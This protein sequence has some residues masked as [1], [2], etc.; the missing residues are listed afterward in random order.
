M[1]LYCIREMPLKVRRLKALEQ[2]VL[3]DPNAIPQN[4]VLLNPSVADHIVYMRDI[5]VNPKPP[6]DHPL[7]LAHVNSIVL[8]DTNT[9]TTIPV[10]SPWQLLPPSLGYYVGLEDLRIIWFRSRLYFTATCTHASARMTSEMMLGVF[11]EDL[12]TVEHISYIDCGS[13]PVKNVCP[14]V[15]DDKL[16]LLDVYNSV[17]YAVKEKKKEKDDDPMAYYVEPMVAL[18][19]PA[20]GYLFGEKRTRGSTSPIHLHGSTWGCVVHDIVYDDNTLLNTKSKLAYLHQWMEFDV[21]TGMVTFV[22]TPFFMAK[23]GVEFASGIN[24]N[25]NDGVVSIYAGLDDKHPI[26]VLTTLHDLR[27]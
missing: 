24:Y 17:I 9:K 22:S 2:H 23:F 14:F 4:H 15:L 13:P 16:V 5:E 26:V 1:F 7:P 21:T 18:T 6:G 8:F 11:A 10:P 19:P 27:A 12:K 3:V 20:T 25:K